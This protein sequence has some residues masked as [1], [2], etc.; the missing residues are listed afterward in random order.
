ML[1]IPIY[2]QKDYDHVQDQLLKA[3]YEW[4]GKKFMRMDIEA[5]SPILIHY[6]VTHNRL[7]WSALRPTD[8][9]LNTALEFMTEIQK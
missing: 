2:T 5:R 6:S 4:R 8:S 9:A 3:G 7:T 1:A